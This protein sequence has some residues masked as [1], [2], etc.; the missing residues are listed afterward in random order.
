MNKSTLIKLT[1]F[2]SFIGLLLLISTGALLQFS[3]P[4]KS[5]GA[6]IWNLTRHEWGSLHFYI[7]IFFLILMV[8]HLLLHIKFIKSA[9]L[10]KA[11]R[12]HNYRLIIGTIALA[13]LMIIL[14]APIFSSVD[15]TNNNES[16]H[17]N[18]NK[19]SFISYN[20]THFT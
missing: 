12:E 17:K 18:R 4:P 8:W 5:G 14:M 9:L 7:A 1:D 19:N 11:N 2:L 16:H 10:G 3:L 6:Q 15:N 20:K 13:V